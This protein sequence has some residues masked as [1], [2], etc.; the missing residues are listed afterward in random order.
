MRAS[1]QRLQSADKFLGALACLLLQPLRL[2]R[3][4]ARKTPPPR[5]ILLVKLWG[6][7][8]LQLLTPAVAALRREFPEARLSLLTLRPNEEFARGLRVFDEVRTL[9]VR[10]ARGAR[11]WCSIFA[12]IARL[13]IALRRARV[14]RGFHL[15]V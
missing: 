9:D 14:G 10:E 13:V 7:G 1:M 4:S 6:I 5:R 12:R 2:L 11:G 8:S 3:S 15:Q